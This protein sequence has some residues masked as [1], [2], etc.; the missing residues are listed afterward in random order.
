LHP[1]QL[2]GRAVHAERHDA[3]HREECEEVAEQ[4][5]DL[6]KPDAADYDVRED[7]AELLLCTGYVQESEVV[8]RELLALDPHVANYWWRIQQVGFATGR[9]ELVDEASANTVEIDPDNRRGRLGRAMLALFQLAG[10]LVLAAGAFCAF[11]I[12]LY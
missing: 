6:R 12:A 1:R 4:A 11:R 7:L 2:R 8:S 10:F 5:D 3:D 9:A